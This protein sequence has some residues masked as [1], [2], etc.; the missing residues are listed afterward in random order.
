MSDSIDEAVE[1]IGEMYEELKRKVYG[2]PRSVVKSLRAYK[3][4][5]KYR[6]RMKPLYERWARGGM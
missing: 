6:R 4:Y 3:I 1:A 2:K 5:L